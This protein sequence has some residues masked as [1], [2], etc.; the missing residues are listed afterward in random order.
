MKRMADE[1]L[2]KETNRLTANVFYVM[3]ALQAA[4]LAVKLLLGGGLRFCALDLLA[5]AAG[6]GT[7]AVLKTLRGLWGSKDEILRELND[8]ALT[9]AFMVMFLVLILGELLLSFID[10]ENMIWCLPTLF[11][12]F[13]PG[14]IITVVSMKRGLILWGGREQKCDGMRILRLSSCIGAVVFAV[15]AGADDCFRDGVFQPLGLVKILLMATVW[16]LLYYGLTVL[17][18]NRGEKAADAAAA[19]AEA[20]EEED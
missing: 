14:S 5:L 19:A 16:G 1:R 8:E 4:V 9:W 13:I 6:A 3:L 20:N 18:R 11:V 15:V 2:R 7:A 12:W 17:M 10:A